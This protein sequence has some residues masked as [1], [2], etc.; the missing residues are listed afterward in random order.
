M[1]S[2]LTLPHSTALTD[3]VG[4][5]DAT[6]D[7]SESRCTLST[8]SLL[9]RRIT[10]AHSTCSTSKSVTIRAPARRADAPPN[11]DPGFPPRSG[12]AFI[13][14]L[15]F[16]SS[17]NAS[18]STIVIM[19]FRATP[20]SLPSDFIFLKLRRTSRGSATPVDSITTTSKVPCMKSN[21]I[22]LSKSSAAVQ[23][24][25]PLDMRTD[26]IDFPSSAGFEAAS[27]MSLAS[28]LTAAT[29]F[30]TTPILAPPSAFVD[31]VSRRCLSVVVFPDPR[32]PLSKTTGMSAMFRDPNCVFFHDKEFK[33]ASSSISM[34]STRVIDA[35]NLLPI[36]YEQPKVVAVSVAQRIKKWETKVS[37]RLRAK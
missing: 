15:D 11:S 22:V 21:S 25:Q 26:W 7:L 5:R 34:G 36:K 4:L 18:E 9:F 16:T 3:A 28:M 23:H 27:R 31:C 32:N 2:S 6:M 10:S 24:T 17:R 19:R 20:F 37:L 35:Q 12:R 13:L 14:S 29:S 8:L 30:A 1:T 33:Y